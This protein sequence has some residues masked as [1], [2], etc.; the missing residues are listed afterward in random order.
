VQI[1]IGVNICYVV[2]VN[3]SG[4]NNLMDIVI[5]EIR[6]ND[7]VSEIRTEAD[8]M[9][10]RTWQVVFRAARNQL[11]LPAGR[12]ASS[13]VGSRDGSQLKRIIV[14]AFFSYI[15]IT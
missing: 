1:F 11:A 5:V 12:A 2:G 7:D 9:F 13:K 15:P 3:P 4:K 14:V 8:S 6:T 10:P